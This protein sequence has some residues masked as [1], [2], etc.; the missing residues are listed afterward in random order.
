MRDGVI[1]QADEDAS[2][3]R[4]LV[5]I[6]VADP[7]LKDSAIIDALRQAVDPVFLPRRIVRVDG[8]PRNETGKLP[9]A[10]I[11]ALLGRA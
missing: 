3:V 9:K 2:G 5:A 1:V 4:R 6:I 7:M 11:D 10:A 8:L